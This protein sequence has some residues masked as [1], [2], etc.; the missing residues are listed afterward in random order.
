[1]PSGFVAAGGL[2]IDDV[3][4]AYVSG[5]KPAN[6]GFSVAG[7]DIK[8]RFQPGS[9]AAATGYMVAG[10]A[11]ISTLFAPMSLLIPFGGP[12]SSSAID[13]HDIAASFTLA[14]KSDGSWAITQVALHG[15]STVGTPVSGTWHAA[16]AV[17]VG[18]GYEV[19]FIADVSVS[20]DYTPTE[21]VDPEY[22]PSTGWL[23]LSTDRSVVADTSHLLGGGADGPGDVTVE[24]SYAVRI[25]KA[26]STNF[27]E[28]I[29]YFSAF[30]MIT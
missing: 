2:D 19:Q 17:G 29:V 11:D 15:G 22:T 28:S 25:R 7:V 14:I 5:V 30:A 18:S 21:N 6:T 20:N 23:S 3:F 26:G 9:T 13:S 4:L 1:M 8:D 27:V 24:G 16:P 12:Y 10:G